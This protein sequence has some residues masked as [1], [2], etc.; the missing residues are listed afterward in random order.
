VPFLKTDSTTGGSWQGVYGADG[1]NVIGAD[2]TNPRYVTVTASSNSQYT[3]ASSTSEPRAL[4]K[5]FSPGDRI[6]ACWYS[7]GS[8]TIDLAFK[9]QNPHQVALYFL[10]WDIYGGG[11]VESID[12]LDG[13]GN[14]LDTRS[15]S[16][17]VNGQYLVWSLTGHVLVRITN[18]NPS[19]NA[20]LSG[21][22]FQ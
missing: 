2:A 14:V 8:F 16:S 1:Y 19:A 13:N 21:L 11:R 20:V 5:P 6:A 18:T 12:I 9:D 22:F 17:F 10:D 7:S 3:W 4:Q 15:V